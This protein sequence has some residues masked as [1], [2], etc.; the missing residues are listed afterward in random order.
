VA[1]EATILVYCASCN[2]NQYR[3]SRP[4]KKGEQLDPSLFVPLQPGIARIPGG[5]CAVCQTPYHFYP[6]PPT[7]AKVSREVAQEVIS[8]ENGPIPEPKPISDNRVSILFE[9]GSDEV[10]TEVQDTGDS[11]LIVTSKRILSVRK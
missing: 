3:S 4:L 1:A 6:E 11:I 10:M 5:A 8:T 7:K 2:E 9:I